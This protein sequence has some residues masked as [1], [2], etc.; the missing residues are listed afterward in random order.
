MKVVVRSDGRGLFPRDAHSADVISRMSKTTDAACDIS[1][2]RNLQQL[3]FIYATLKTIAD[4][5]PELHSVEAVKKE[6]KVRSRMF[7][8]FVSRDGKLYF[9]LRST[10]FEKMDQS[11]FA[12]VWEQWRGIIVSELLPGITD[13]Q[14]AL[15]IMG[16]L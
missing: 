16:S 12:L 8:P 13:D 6:L 5:H 1:Q 11:E 10:S 15:E 4:N 3:R 2:P 9:A 7:D 14:L